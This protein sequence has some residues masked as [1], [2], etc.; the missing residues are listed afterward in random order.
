[1]MVAVK[2]LADGCFSRH[3]TAM[4]R[5]LC[6]LTTILLA[7]CSLNP[8]G[9]QLKEGWSA[10]SLAAWRDHHPDMMVFSADGKYLY[11]S[12]E[13]QGGLL[14]PSLISINLETNQ[15]HTLLFGLARA[16]ALKLSPDG[17]LWIGEEVPDGLF[18]RITEPDKLLDEQRVDRQQLQSSIPA[19][20]PLLLAGR[21]SH[22]GLTFSLDGR[23]AYM[24][25]EWE[26]GTIYRFDMHARKLYVLHKQN[27]WIAIREPNHARIDAEKLHAQYFDRIEDMETLPDGRIL[28]A[29]T[30]T[31]RVLVLDDSQEK[32]SVQTWLQHHNLIHPDN[33]AWDEQRG[34]LW[35]TDDDQPSYLWAWDG[36]ELRE[37]ARHEDSEIT[38]VTIHKGDIY[39]NLQRGLSRPEVLL[40]IRENTATPTP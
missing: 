12:C 22:E 38:G 5:Y 13:T 17:S 2:H 20:A 4:F 25:D 27:G 24:A 19:I 33:L 21:F 11:V 39:I 32:P 36:Q 34:W 1:M 35:I 9:I 18:W 6:V 30:G 7:G 8:T 10:R 16:D 26:E 37:I 15:R 23:F 40:H 29:E 31:G 3:I 14:S 28:L